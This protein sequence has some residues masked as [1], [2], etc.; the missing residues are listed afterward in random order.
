MRSAPT[1]FKRHASKGLIEDSSQIPTRVLLADDD[2]DLRK[3]LALALRQEGYEVVEIHDGNHLRTYLGAL[4]YNK[5]EADPVDLIISDVRMPGPNGMETLEWLR[6]AVWSIP[7]II[8]TSFGDPEIHA[9]AH[10]LGALAVLDKPFDLDE[11]LGLLRVHAPR[12]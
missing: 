11:L 3:V 9:E 2:K 4:L 12:A 5:Y 10:R 1:E 8:I 6:Q 7:V